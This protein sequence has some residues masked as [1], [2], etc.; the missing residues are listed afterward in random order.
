[1]PTPWI[2]IG[3]I[4][5]RHEKEQAYRAV[6]AKAENRIED[7]RQ[8]VGKSL[9]D[10]KAKQRGGGSRMSLRARPPDNERQFVSPSR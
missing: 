9:N 10:R 7:L 5:H 4:A 1:M 8:N 2:I 6:Y 3:K